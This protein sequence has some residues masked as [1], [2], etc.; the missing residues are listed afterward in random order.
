M[1][2]V[3]LISYKEESIVDFIT[4]LTVN[5]DIQTVDV[6]SIEKKPKENQYSVKLFL[7][8]KPNTKI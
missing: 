8:F 5:E 6:K 2:D 1:A 7:V 3:D 4:N